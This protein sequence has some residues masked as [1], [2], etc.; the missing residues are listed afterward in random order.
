MTKITFLIIFLF[1]SVNSFAQKSGKIFYE[2]VEKN[3][4]LIDEFKKNGIDIAFG[5]IK[6]D[7]KSSPK[8]QKV[9]YDYRLFVLTWY[10]QVN[11]VTFLDDESFSRLNK[12]GMIVQDIQYVQAKDYSYQWDGKKAFDIPHVF[13]KI[14]FTA[15]VTEYSDRF[16]LDVK[17]AEETIK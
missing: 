6:I 5:S 2:N 1:F 15:K 8:I 17:F 14:F 10:R 11:S 4:A 7:L 13:S 12:K 3:N 16:I 9:I